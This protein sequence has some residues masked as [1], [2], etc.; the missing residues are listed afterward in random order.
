[1]KRGK[2]LKR[3]PLKRGESKLKSKTPINK[4]SKKMKDKYVER[5]KVVEQMLQS[6]K[7]SACVVYHVYDGYMRLPDPKSAFSA[8]K[9]GVCHVRK[10][11]DV[12]EIVNRSQGGDILDKS[13]LLAV[14]RPCHRRITENPLE[15]EMVGLHLPRWLN[16]PAGLA[17]AK[18]IRI[19]FINGKFTEPFWVGD[20]E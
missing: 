14:C 19:N 8:P 4:R 10:T 5:R 18:R 20:D 7:C 11:Q 13:N 2:P 3:T 16:T 12:H 1:M 17:E 6:Q 9:L 15:A